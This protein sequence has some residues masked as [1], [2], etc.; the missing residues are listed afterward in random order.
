MGRA[1]IAT[2]HHLASIAG[3]DML[4]KGG[5]AVDAI[6]AAAMVLTVVEPTGCGIGGDGFAILWD[7]KQLHG[8]NGS[9]RSPAA[10]TPEYFEGVATVPERGWGSVT[11]PGVVSTWIALWERCGSLSLE[12]IA[13]PA[14]RHARDGFAV[15]PTI[16]GLWASG[17]RTLS[18]QPGFAECFLPGGRA[19]RAGELFR[20]AAHAATLEAIV[21]TRGEAFYRGV[22]AERIVADARAHGAALSL[23]DLDEHRA[24]W[25]GTIAQR[26]A[27]G[28]V[29]ELPPANQG[30]ATLIGLGILEAAGWQ[31]SSP[32]D[33]H[34]LHLAIEA[35]KLA[36]ADVYRH[37]ADVDAMRIEPT[38][39]LD[40][41]YLKERARLIDPD[42]AGDP[43]HGEPRAGG[44]VC[45]SAADEGGMMVSF[46]QSNYKGFGSGV[47]V[48][49][50][51]I[52][53]HNRGIGFTLAPGH[54]NQ[55]GPRKRPFHTIIPG[56]AMDLKGA[57]LMAFGLMGGP[58]QAQGHL[59]IALR[60]L[61]YGQ[62]PQA[63]ADA[64]RW[65]ID[66]GRRVGIEPGT[67]PALIDYLRARGHDIVNEALDGTF[68]FG[69]A[70]IVLKTADGY[71]AGS[72]PRKDGQA[73][74]R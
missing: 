15:T 70:Q 50:T 45:L 6:V 69:G 28:V 19:P 8:L 65:R 60:I 13:A 49:D 20:S 22:L 74:A 52:A 67:D 43:G 66:A 26:F 34:Q 48:P 73:L 44:T 39:F 30:L 71:V 47:V 2:S 23:S 41:G 3:M 54:V 29:H 40:P 61:G 18:G 63:A 62:N 11:V 57:P 37:L 10:W 31:P 36:L 27:H 5:N 4:A 24:E 7:G 68:S 16:A 35:T 42:R 72:D 38:A 33:P 14:I 9:G 1:A 25:V 56:F 59:Q 21:A 64:P 53:L 12:A 55:V 32:D 17:G 46:I 51:G 58:M